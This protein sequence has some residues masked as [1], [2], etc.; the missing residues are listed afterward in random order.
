V[1]G[2]LES[3]V[4]PRSARAGNA[5]SMRCPHRDILP[6]PSRSVAI[7]KSNS[8]RNVWR[9]Q[10]QHKRGAW[11]GGEGTG[12]GGDRGTTCSKHDEQQLSLSHPH[13]RPKSRPSNAHAQWQTIDPLIGDR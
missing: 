2:K 8:A 7:S 11:P 9:L 10:L 12:A 6:I 4:M 5:K 1:Q 3:L 13:Q